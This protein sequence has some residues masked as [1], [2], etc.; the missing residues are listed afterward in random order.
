M[1]QITFH[2]LLLFVLHPALWDFV[3]LATFLG[4]PQTEP[5]Q[6]QSYLRCLNKEPPYTQCYL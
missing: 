5:V 4:E 1:K 3:F 2:I 6:L